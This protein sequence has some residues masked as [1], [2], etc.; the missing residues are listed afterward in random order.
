VLAA[1]E[2]FSWPRTAR[3]ALERAYRLRSA[4]L[5]TPERSRWREELAAA[6]GETA[7][8]LVRAGGGARLQAFARMFGREGVIDR[9]RLPL[10]GQD[11]AR[12]RATG[13]REIGR[14]E[15]EQLVRLW[16]DPRSVI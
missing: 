13:D 10:R 1:A 2:G 6:G 8:L 14:L 16:R 4:V 5:S 15:R 11:L 3:L 7:L 9:T 12:A